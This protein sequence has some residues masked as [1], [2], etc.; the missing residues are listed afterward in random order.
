M[1]F[2]V[3]ENG[4]SVTSAPLAG[5]VAAGFH[6]KRSFGVGAGSP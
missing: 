6:Q 1:R 2:L 5:N 4:M 3:D